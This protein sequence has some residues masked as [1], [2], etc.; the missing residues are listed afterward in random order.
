MFF[1]VLVNCG[2]KLID[3]IKLTK[4]NQATMII[5]EVA[6]LSK[7]SRADNSIVIIFQEMRKGENS[8]SSSA[9]FMIVSDYLAF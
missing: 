1:Y 8:D 5:S 4:S 9:L 7:V 6:Y 2:D 3:K